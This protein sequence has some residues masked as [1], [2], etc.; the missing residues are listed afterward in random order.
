MKT[1]FRSQDTIWCNLVIGMKI[2]NSFLTL[3]TCSAIIS[4]AVK[5]RQTDFR[6]EVVPKEEG[7]N[8]KH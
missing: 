4:T 2:L 8:P 7:L 6:E 1:K 5:W 3:F